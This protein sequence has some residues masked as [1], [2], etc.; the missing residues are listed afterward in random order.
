M[1]A[2]PL[3]DFEAARA[4]SEESVAVFR[5]V[6]E[7]VEIGRALAGLGAKLAGLGEVARARELFEEAAELLRASGDTYPLALTLGNLADLAI[8]DGDHARAE[9]LL[10]EV[11]ALHREPGGE[12]GTQ[13]ALHNLAL[14][15]LELGRDD[16]ALAAATES[17]A[18]S[19]AVA[20]ARFAVLSL[21]VLAALAARRGD[22]AA[23]ARLLGTADA[24]RERVGFA[25][26]GTPEAELGERTR[27]DVRGRLGAER[28]AE[29]FAEGR[30]TA[31]ADL[32]AA[33]LERDPAPISAR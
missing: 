12:H 28:F 20:D 26:D 8:R 11:L 21:C 17:L 14:L 30:A 10:E 29:A 23:A 18:F 5:E 19:H 16:E 33:S 24:E 15:R 13:A 2:L 7:P 4:Y 25:F 31:I 3:G 6:G 27:D 32:V 22:D 1:F 9:A